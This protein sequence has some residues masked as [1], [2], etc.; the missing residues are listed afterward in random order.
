MD[1]FAKTIVLGAPNLAVALWALF[2]AFRSIEKKDAAMQKLTDQ[3][4]LV[5]TERERLRAQLNG[6]APDSPL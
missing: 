5:I 4:L 6:N 3:L 2:W 1:E